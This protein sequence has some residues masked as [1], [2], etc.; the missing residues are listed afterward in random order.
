[1]RNNSVKFSSEQKYK[2]T[3]LY[4]SVYN[5]KWDNRLV[6][7]TIYVVNMSVF[8]SSFKTLAVHKA[9]VYKTIAYKTMNV[10]ESYSELP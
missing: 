6:H 7:I 9:M 5:D 10:F 1:M 4:L 8:V 2:S 3:F